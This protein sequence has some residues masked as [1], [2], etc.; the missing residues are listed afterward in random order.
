MP[1]KIDPEAVLWS[2]PERERAN[3]PLLV[4]LHGYGSHE[5]DLFSLSPY[6][7]LTPVIAS[8]RAPL[9][10]G[11][12]WSWF[13]LP[14][15]MMHDD[16]MSQEAEAAALALVDWL[17]SV[18]ADS[19]GVLG[20]SQGGAMAIQLMRL[21]PERVEFAVALAG[22]VIPGEQSADSRM[23]ELRPPVFWGRGTI[24]QVIPAE[25]VA[26]TSSW[27]PQRSTLTER[28]Y[29]DLGHAVSEAELRDVVAFL[30]ERY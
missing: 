2:A 14:A 19:V 6:L 17:D 28:I 4:L 29:E 26:Y 24:D 25:S 9:A 20:F 22:F 8:L 12:G 21:V 27:L 7:P 5:G 11:M 10:E 30:H 18:G 23:R 3:R 13:S 15:R 16:R 1:V